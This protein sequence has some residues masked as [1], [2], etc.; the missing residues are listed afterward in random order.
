MSK[1]AD[2]STKTAKEHVHICAHCGAENPPG[3]LLCLSCGRDPTTGR[4]LFTPPD[5]AASAAG[6]SYDLTV[7][8]PEPIQ[9]PDPL[10]IPEP[11]EFL[12]PP[13]GPQAAPSPTV[14]S[15]P[16]LP[17]EMDP[18]LSPLPRGMIL[19]AGLTTLAVL[20]AAVAASLVALN[21]GSAICLGSMWLALAFFW[22]SLV[23][24]RRGESRNMATYAQRQLVTSLGRRLFEVTPGPAVEQRV[25]MPGRHVLP[26]TQ[27]ASHLLYLSSSGGRSEQLTQVLLGTLCALVAG[28]HI[29][30]ASQ[31]YDVRTAGLFQSKLESVKRTAVSRRTLYVGAGYL[32]RLIVDQVRHAPAISVRDLAAAV[33]RQ[34]GADLLERVAAEASGAPAQPEKGPDVD[35]QVGALREYCEELKALNPD[36]VAQMAQEVEEAV[37]SFSRAAWQR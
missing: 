3:L 28:E 29:D 34:A 8:L 2:K 24:A 17:R 35:A 16:P 19:L 37:R 30:L 7:R 10:P 20:G 32:E 31:A 22:L 36:L 9:V 4:D 13:A 23:L 15:P 26:L 11:E 27:P 6:P 12:A 25:R 18:V 33:L 1:D 14:L 21:L 5:F